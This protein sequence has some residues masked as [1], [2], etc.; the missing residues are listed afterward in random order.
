VRSSSGAEDTRGE[1]NFARTFLSSYD[2]SVA[3]MVAMMD[4]ICFTPGKKGHPVAI[5]C[6][7]LGEGGFRTCRKRMAC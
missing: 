3:M 5:W 4:W 6:N 1:K 2:Q 7:R